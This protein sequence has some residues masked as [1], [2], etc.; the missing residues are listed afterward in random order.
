MDGQILIARLIRNSF[1][2]IEV[3]DFPILLPKAVGGS[4]GQVRKVN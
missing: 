1:V 4:G 2:E 3:L